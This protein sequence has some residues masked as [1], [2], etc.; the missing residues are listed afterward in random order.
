MSQSCG[1]ALALL[2]FRFG[3]RFRG[4]TAVREIKVF[5]GHGSVFPPGST[6]NSTAGREG[7]VLVMGPYHFS[8]FPIGFW[9]DGATTDACRL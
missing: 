2:R 5:L 9:T 1:S 6:P 4:S 3:S 7:K 8:N